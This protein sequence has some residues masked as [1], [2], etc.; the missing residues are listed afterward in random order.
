MCTVILAAH[1]F[2]GHPLVVLANRD[3]QLD[4]A[5][6][7]PRVWAPRRRAGGPFIAPRDDVAGGTWLGVNRAGVFVGITNRFLGP[8]DPARESRGT[9][10]VDALA[11]GSAR[12]IHEA[13]AKVPASRH[14]GFH[15]VYADEHDV[16]ATAS[17]GTHVA[18][19]TLGRGIHALTERSFGAGDDSPRLARIRAAWSRLARQSGGERRETETRISTASRSS[20][21]STTTPISSRRHASTRRASATERAAAPPSRSAPLASAIARA[22][23][24]GPKARRAPR[25]S[26]RWI[27]RR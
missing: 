13:M 7:P 16:L 12:E 3:E 18:Q 23:C 2:V 1:V 9:L 25:R 27:S 21:P 20:S 24:S 17:N 14:N 8:K 19:L 5:S 11:L 26:R 15:L 6:S 4:R 10:V 22:A